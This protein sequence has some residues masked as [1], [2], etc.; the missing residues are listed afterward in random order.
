[1]L[2]SFPSPCLLSVLRMSS[3]VKSAFDK[4]ADS[5][6][7]KETDKGV[8]FR[9]AGLA[10]LVSKPLAFDAVQ[11]TVDSI[12]KR[13]PNA[14]Q[15]EVHRTPTDA[16]IIVASPMPKGGVLPDGLHRCLL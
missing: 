16:G 14:P 13:I 7:T 11:D 6:Q 10:G 15:V 12:L 1:M 3:G 8:M 5:I 4:L 2:R 9:S